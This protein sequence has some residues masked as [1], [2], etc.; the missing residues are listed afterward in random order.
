[1]AGRKVRKLFWIFVSVV[2]LLMLLIAALPFWFPLALRPIAKRFGATYADY[3]RVGYQYFQLSGLALTNGAVQIHAENARALVPSVWLWR[4]FTGSKDKPF[5]EISSWQYMRGP[6]KSTRSNAPASVYSTFEDIDKLARTLHKWLPNAT[7][8]NGIININNRTVTV[9]EAVW[10]NRTLA[11]DVLL[12]NQPPFTLKLSTEPSGPWKL[13]FDWEAQQLHSIVSLQDRGQK[14]TVDG[15]GNWLTNHFNL[16]AEFPARGLFP[17]TA[18]LSA[19]SFDVPP[20]L[21]GLAQ[22]SDLTGNLHAGWQTNRFDAQL[23]ATAMPQGTNLPPF[24]LELRAAGD[25]NSVQLNL[26]QISAPGLQAGLPA[27]AT[28]QFHPP[29]LL[30]PTTLNVTADLDVLSQWSGAAA[31]QQL[32]GKLSGEAIVYPTWGIPNVSFNLSGSSLATWYITTSNLQV[33]ADLK[34]PLL[35]LKSTHI[36]M[37]DASQISLTGSYD[38]KQKTVSDGQV[39]FSG[40]FGRQ[41]LPANYSFGSASLTGQFAGPLRELTNSASLEV[42]HVVAPP[43]NPMDAEARWSA[44]GLSFK[45]AQ[46]KLTAG[47]SSFQLRGSA[48]LAPRQ[49]RLALTALDLIESNQPAL[50]LEQPANLV[51][52]LSRTNAGL[53]TN[54]TWS[55]TVENLALTGDNR[56][57]RLAA[58]VN[59]P[60]RGTL[61]CDAEGMDAH[62][63]KDFIPQAD[64]DARLS[65]FNFSGGWTNGPVEFQLVSDATL[66]TR[67]QIPFTANAKLTG[68]KTGIVIE[69]LSVS[70]TTQAVCRAEGTLPIYC[71]P[72]RSDSILQ[73]DAEAPLKLQFLT[74]PNS[75]LWKK[76]GEASGLQLQQP[77][78]TANLSGTWAAPQGEVKMQVQRI[79]LPSRGH[80]LPSVDNL[81]LAAVMDRTSARISHCRFEIE[82]QPVTLTGEIPLG[83]SFWSNLRHQRRLPNWRDATG[84]LTIDNARIAA[85]TSYLPEIL[86]AEGTASADIFLER[87]GN[88]HGE[89]SIANARTH[90]LESIGPVRN[91][92]ARALLNGQT[93]RLENSFAEVG[94]QQINVEGSLQLNEQLLR[95]N[96]LPQF[97]VHLTGTNVPLARNPNVL[98]RASL[99]LAVTNSGSEVPVISGTVNLTNSLYLADLHSLVPEHKA[100]PRQ[101]PPYFSLEAEPWANWR[102]KLNVHGTGFLR[103]QT[104]LFQGKVSTTMNLEGTLKNPLAL[105]QVQIDTGSTIIFPFG[106]LDVKQGLFSLTSQ[107]PYRP[108]MFVDA[109]S[110]R[111]GYDVK[112]QVT[113]PV[114]QPVIQ[115]SSIPSLTSEEIVLMLTAGQIPA[116]L[117]ASTTMQQRAAGL[118]VYV[119]KNLLADFGLG[120]TGQERL[121]VRSGEY[122]S[123]T[124]HPT[125]DVE[126]KFTDRWSAIGSYDRF[127]QYVLDL[128]WKMY[129]K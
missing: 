97:Q 55:A 22:Y 106:I 112:L 85:F 76:I 32:Q 98:L 71:D 70:S 117:G 8:T 77:N 120:G 56:S 81:D 93:I 43:F 83:E 109:G 10:T 54:A 16:A 26:A 111:Y 20:R 53:Q 44:K 125:Y 80:A 39:R 126:Y 104:P 38:I 84:H 58:D 27:P 41:F 78:L 40:T 110:R 11:G 28:I 65:D 91:I 48:E 73:I 23:S 79:A 52:N 119:G 105:G 95:T 37:D 4:H 34:W 46:I 9:P 113:G 99:D 35:Q 29:F 102:L 2:S 45:D 68:G 62:L 59:W 24:H 116:G 51:F 103:V 115:F 60:E 100:S 87:G 129:S 12:S 90:P 6:G 123:Q 15:T 72:S 50:R 1:M 49:M 75:V 82:K 121:T 107:D 101:R 25:T 88:L 92:H 127:D 63:L 33:N 42:K 124:G 69:R 74:D 5:L 94:G 64:A 17:E 86:S 14:L 19:D 96:G 31:P 67:E 3:Q 89:V 30:Q 18:S 114:D 122:V 108:T 66:K 36:E 21:L 7:L 118:G 128:K 47:S 61:Q 57:F 13:T